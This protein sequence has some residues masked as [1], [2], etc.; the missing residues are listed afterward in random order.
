MRQA[1]AELSSGRQVMER[2]V[3]PFLTPSVFVESFLQ[4]RWSSFRFAV[5]LRIDFVQFAA[6]VASARGLRRPHSETAECWLN[7]KTARY[8]LRQAL[9][10]GRC[11]RGE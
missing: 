7:A 2:V 5:F 6:V 8:G 9:S 10:V 1:P 4:D 3:V 11:R